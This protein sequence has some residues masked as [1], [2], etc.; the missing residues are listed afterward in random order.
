MAEDDFNV[1]DLLITAR[2]EV[3]PALQGIAEEQE[4]TAKKLVDDIERQTAAMDA[5]LA[6]MIELEQQFEMITQAKQTAREE[7]LRS[8]EQQQK[9]IEK[10]QVEIRKSLDKTEKEL[11]K[12]KE[13]YNDLY[14]AAKNGGTDYGKH[15]EKIHKKEISSM[16]EVRRALRHISQGYRGIRPLLAGLGGASVK[17]GQQMR[18]S[19]NSNIAA[20]NDM[21]TN[22]TGVQEAFV[23]MAGVDFT[24]TIQGLS[25]MA[26]Q[27]ELMKNMQKQGQSIGKLMKLNLALTAVQALGPAIQKTID[28]FKNAADAAR[29]VGIAVAGMNKT[30]Q[31]RVDLAKDTLEK[32]K[33]Y[34]KLSKDE[35]QA[36]ANRIE[37]RER[38]AR[39]YRAMSGELERLDKRY[40]TLW[41]WRNKE[42]MELNQKEQEVLKNKL[43]DLDKMIG[44]LGEQTEA[45]KQMIALRKQAELL[46]RDEDREKK[47]KQMRD[48]LEIRR[49][50]N[51]A[52]AVRLH[53]AKQ[54]A[55]EDGRTGPEFYKY[56]DSVKEE[57]AM[58]KEL[59]KLRGE[60]QA[61]REGQIPEMEEG[62]VDQLKVYVDQYNAYNDKRIK[63]AEDY[64]K[65]LEDQLKTEKELR[66]EELDRLGITGE[67]AQAM[68]EQEGEM[69][70]IKDAGAN[71]LSAIEG[72][73]AGRFTT[74]QT[75]ERMTEAERKQIELQQKIEQTAQ[76]QLTQIKK[77]VGEFKTNNPT[78]VYV[79]Q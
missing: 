76:D 71:P 11:V 20:L 33:L 62:A 37:G 46:D 45:E 22:A 79:E 73:P 39:Q 44:A 15:L 5:D 55:H 31:M 13:A 67:I 51:D 63:Y 14:D 60:E 54:Q 25:S 74:G 19:F 78:M 12:N 26:E 48:E 59:A 34:I 43:A 50:T 17:T 56:L 38:I 21:R 7:E 3:S 27:L 6:K 58:E 2:D 68:A 66:L 65:S 30:H 24:S 8:L 72:T 16:H 53:F 35:A 9:E 42:E 41:S 52:D 64:Q 40:K 36:E 29:Q 75:T 77:L 70:K 4:K 1:L 10:Q 57:I 61:A 49:K 32:T 47:L 23:A 18:N 28:Y 69:Q